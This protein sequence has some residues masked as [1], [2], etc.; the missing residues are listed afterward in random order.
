M[1]KLTALIVL[2]ALLLPTVALAAATYSAPITVT[3]SGG[4][5]YTRLPISVSVDN[6]YLVTNNFIS[7]TGLDTRVLAASTEL[8][9]MVASDRTLFAADIAANTQS[10][11]SYTTGNSALS[12]FPV[13]VGYSGYVT[14]ADDAA[15]ELG[16][17][18]EIEQKGYVDTSAGSDKNLVYKD[19]AFRTYIS[20]GTNVTSEICSSVS[21]YSSSSD[22]NI[23]AIGGN[24]STANSATS[25]TVNSGATT[26]T[27]GQSFPTISQNQTA[28]DYAVGLYTGSNVR[29]GERVNGFSGT[30]TNVQW[31]LY[32]N[33]APTGTAYAY[34]RNATSDAI[35]GTLG[36]LNVATLTTSAA[37]YS[38]PTDVAVTTPTDIR[39]TLEY[40]GGD[41]SNFV[42]FE[43]KSTDVTAWGVFT[44]YSTGWSDSS[45]SDATFKIDYTQYRIDRAYAY[46]DTS[47]IP[48]SA[49][50]W[51]AYLKL[52]GS[53]DNSTTDFNITVQS[54]MP[55]YPTDPPAATD[56]N[57]TYY[58]GDG[59]SLSTSGF[60]T[61]GYNTITL[62]STG[63]GWINKT[64]TSKFCLRSSRDIAATTPTG[65]EYV[66]VYT[67]EQTGTSQDPQL[68]VNYT[69]VAATV[70]GISS[71]ELIVKT[72]ADGTNMTLSVTNYTGTHQGNS[73]QSVALSGASVPNNSN[74]WTL[75][76]NNVIPYMDYYKHTVGGTLIAWYQPVTII[77]GTTLPDRQGTA[78]DGTITWGSNP[79][80]VAVSIGAL[81]PEAAPVSPTEAVTG[82]PGF[83]PKTD[84]DSVTV[85]GV[86]GETFPFYAM[87]KGL[88]KDWHDLGG[89]N[90][91]MPYFWKLVAVVLGWVFGTA[92]MLTTRNVFFGVIAYFIGF[93][94][95]AGAM[96]GV[97]DLW[98]P[99]VYALG[100]IATGLLTAKW[101]ASSL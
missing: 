9:H 29:A 83:V 81:L 1:R 41:A 70:T 55:T 84:I 24:Y 43:D 93:A 23:Y 31:Y 42:G 52:Y 68:V 89:P 76:Q 73:P 28:A 16:S 72:T 100:A 46:F 20:A 17:N 58:S 96:G 49:E 54:G 45:T 36:T 4:S 15:L 12:D 21:P 27:I 66:T 87:F 78:Q 48:D 2:L 6:D 62:N 98:V 57:K 101:G 26:M 7:S 18:F 97:L 34:V 91:S 10:T 25:G 92:V 35:I 79:A 74:S 40:T 69:A 77:S 3:E 86:E 64:G 51:S 39:I 75:M 30:I 53:T 71:G 32:K 11:F 67:N 85:P 56:F 22:A 37:W 63:L 50:I 95:P 90:I 5:S 80:G 59:G 13:I 99:I 61:T 82:G 88:L 14:T 19:G 60:S 65:D 47:A 94:V 44:S 33:G 38:F 8:P